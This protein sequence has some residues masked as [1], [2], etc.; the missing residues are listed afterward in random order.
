MCI[1]Y[2]HECIVHI[3]FDTY[4]Y[5]QLSYLI[6]VKLFLISIILAHASCVFNGSIW[7][8]GGKTAKYI[9]YNLLDAYSIA[10][11]WKSQDGG[12]IIRLLAGCYY[13]FVVFFSYIMLMMVTRRFRSS[14]Y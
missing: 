13:C 12:E 5:D 10:D 11:V 9:Q 2:T 14:S 4:I 6:I 1:V 8:T 7:V 3:Y